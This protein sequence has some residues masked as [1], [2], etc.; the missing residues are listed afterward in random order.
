MGK[1]ILV[2]GPARSGKSEWAESLIM[3]SSKAIIYIATATKNPD[4]EEWGLRIQKHQKRRPESW[5]T[6]EVTAELS[7]TLADAKPNTCFLIDS[8]GTWVANLL[9]QDDETWSNT[10]TELLDTVDLVACDMIFVAEE[11]GW[12]VI[13][14]YALGRTFRDRLGHLV[15]CLSR[16]CDDVYLVTGGYALN[17]SILGTPLPLEG[18]REWGVG[19]G[20]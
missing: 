8:L 16:L 5:V 20:D 2:T 17:L 12:G 11:A 10:V 15:R 1:A 13:P 9:T 18:S 14:A 3:Q 4:D 19:S 6:L 7:V